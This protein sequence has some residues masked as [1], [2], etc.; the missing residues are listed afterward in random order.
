L[1]KRLAKQVKKVLPLAKRGVS[2]PPV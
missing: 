2:F 1:A